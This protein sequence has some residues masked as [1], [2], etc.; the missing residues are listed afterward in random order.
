MSHLSPKACQFFDLMQ[1]I[2]KDKIENEKGDN[3]KESSDHSSVNSNINS[4]VND[5]TTEKL[6][7][8]SRNAKNERRS[9]NKRGSDIINI[10]VDN[11]DF[12]E[13]ISE[14]RL[15]LD[16]ERDAR[17]A[18]IHYNEVISKTISWFGKESMNECSE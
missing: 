15:S 2:S 7:D 18:E 11:N 17:N 5:N 16:Q 8:I 1:I 14:L 10:D 3:S 9:K 13:S 6:G 12:N 4:N